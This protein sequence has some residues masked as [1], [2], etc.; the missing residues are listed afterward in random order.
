MKQLDKLELRKL[1]QEDHRAA[2]R[3]ESVRPVITAGL[4]AAGSYT[5]MFGVVGTATAAASAGE[6]A[7]VA[8]GTAAATVTSA[9]AAAGGL[10]GIATMAA[11]AGGV[12]LA[13]GGVAAAV[14]A[15]VQGAR[16]SGV[17][18]FAQSWANA[19]TTDSDAATGNDST[20]DSQSAEPES[21]GVAM[22]RQNSAEQR[23]QRR[24]AEVETAQLET[25]GAKSDVELT[26][27]RAQIAAVQQG[28]VTEAEATMELAEWGDPTRQAWALA[29]VAAD[30]PFNV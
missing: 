15:V 17:G 4:V 28:G 22:V 29:T 5:G 3:E 23:R 7:L 6:A 8:G 27:V 19:A 10:A 24:A 25:T 11:A 1:L 16:C 30:A 26:A 18:Q 13:A 12:V 20:P 9:T 21:A 14:G 2:R